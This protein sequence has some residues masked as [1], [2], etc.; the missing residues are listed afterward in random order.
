MLKWDFHSTP[1]VTGVRLSDGFESCLRALSLAGGRASVRGRP[2][3][4]SG[5]GRGGGV[6]RPVIQAVGVRWG[7]FDAMRTGYHLLRRSLLRD[8]VRTMGMIY[9]GVGLVKR[10]PPLRPAW[11]VSRPFAF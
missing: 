6:G 4:I 3:I 11:R 9:Y 2:L 5:G 8:Q 1:T 7:P 10:L